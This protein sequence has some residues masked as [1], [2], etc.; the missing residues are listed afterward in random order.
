M[1]TNIHTHVYWIYELHE[2]NR[3]GYR[4]AQ[5]IAGF[6]RTFHFKLQLFY[7]CWWFSFQTSILSMCHTSIWCSVEMKV[8]H[9]TPNFS[10]ILDHTFFI[11]VSWDGCKQQ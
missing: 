2:K 11:D 5:F 10:A 4:S 1:L 3:K 6:V 9:T 7:I 8:W